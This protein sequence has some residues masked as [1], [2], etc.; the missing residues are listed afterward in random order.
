MT[1]QDQLQQIEDNID[2]SMQKIREFRESMKGFSGL[3]RPH[4]IQHEIEISQAVIIRLTVRRDRIK[5]KHNL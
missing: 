2:M 4:E 5:F 3:V 1:P